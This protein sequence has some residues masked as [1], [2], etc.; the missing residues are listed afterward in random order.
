MRLRASMAIV[1]LLTDFGHRDEYVGV[2]KGV[3]LGEDPNATIVDLCHRIDAQD[4]LAAAWMLRAAVP[5]FPDGTIHLVIVDP[6]VGTD[7]LIVAAKSQNHVLIAPDNGILMPV[8]K[9]WPPLDIRRVENDTWFR[10]PISGTFHGRDI[11]APVAGRLSAGA[12]FDAVG[13]PVSLEALQPLQNDSALTVTHDEI[14]GVVVAIDR[15][16][17]LITNIDKSDLAH[18]SSASVVIQVG[19]HRLAGI[20]PNYA[21]VRHGQPVAVIG[22]RNCLEIAVNCGHAASTLGVGKLDVVRLRQAA[23]T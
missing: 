11:F 6:G 20:A 16:G 4:T 15:F 12:P 14:R 17:N 8:L 23:D 19:A 13:S 21:Q 2:L 3:L 1:S 5:F 18:L 7:R 9:A 22:S 10:S